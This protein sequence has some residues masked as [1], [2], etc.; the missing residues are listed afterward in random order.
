VK[1]HVKR[2]KVATV[3]ALSDP[4]L[5][6]E[7]IASGQADIVELARGLIAD[8][9]L[10]NKAREG[11]D[12]EIRKCIRCMTCFSSLLSK[13]QFFCAINPKAGRD[14][15][16]KYTQPAPKKQR[17][18]IAGG[19]IAGM[20][21]AVTCADRGHE[22]TLCEKTAKLGGAL[23]CEENVP[24]KANLSRYIEYQRRRVAD[25]AVD[26]RL[27][28]PVTEELA[29]SLSPDVII[30]ALGAKPV[31]PNIPG[32]D[33]PRGAG[34]KSAVSAEEVYENPGLAGN[35]VVIL[36]AGLVGTELGIYLA[37]LGRKVTIV[38][39]AD[40]IADG[41]NFLHTLGVNVQIAKLG[42][43]ILF[44]TKATAITASGVICESPNGET[45]VDA[46]TVIYA[47]GQAP[48]ADDADTLRFL[49]PRFYQIGDCLAP[50]SVH[51]AT[52][53]AYA[54]AND[55]GRF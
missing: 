1:K 16:V 55:V 49:A 37:Q 33:A 30:A 36:G 28:T 21:A 34:G 50:K 41:G 12:G 10:P 40:K 51:A 52:S 2:S 7:I 32:I 4:A 47:V 17:V 14:L 6:E 11:R 24:F 42:V 35:S 23:L 29:R 20:Q 15:E 53:S 8:P 48:L 38:E 19:G 22:V 25:A 54:I 18:L 39:M 13:G 3:G 27:N 26:V 31:K 9:D 44:N 45:S 46:D 43:S 5:L